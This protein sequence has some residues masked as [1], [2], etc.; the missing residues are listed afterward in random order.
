MIDTGTTVGMWI[1]LV[2][3]GVQTEPLAGTI[4]REVLDFMYQDL[5]GA[6]W[7]EDDSTYQVPCNTKLNISL[8]F[9]S[10]RAEP[11]YQRH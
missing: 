6:E 3:V 1:L 7:S 10:V 4:P 9:R 2:D 11:T 5:P 8:V